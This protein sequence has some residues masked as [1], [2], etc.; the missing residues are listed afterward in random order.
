MEPTNSNEKV[1]IALTVIASIILLV[2]L[3]KTIIT[4]VKEKKKYNAIKLEVE[5]KEL[6]MLIFKREMG[7]ICDFLLDPNEKNP[8]EKEG[9]EKQLEKNE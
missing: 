9:H 8:F 2:L 4:Y 6:Q 3:V 7:V 1:F 5:L